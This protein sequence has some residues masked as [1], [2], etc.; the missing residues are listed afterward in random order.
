MIL[1]DQSA[2]E[3]STFTK[4]VI[5]AGLGLGL[6]L[7]FVDSTSVATAA[8]RIAKDLDAGETIGWMGTSYLVAK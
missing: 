6:F 8:P 7:S 4:S 5:F 1:Q 3:T 2:T